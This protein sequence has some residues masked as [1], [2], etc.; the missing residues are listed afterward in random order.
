MDK[1]IL[2]KW[3]AAGYVERGQ[4]YPTEDGVPQGGLISATLLVVTLSGLERAIKAVVKKR[5][6]AKVNVCIYAD[7]FI[8]TGASREILEQRIMPVVVAFL[9]ERG[10]DL[11][12]DKTQISDIDQGFDFLSMSIR[13]YNNK[14]IIKPAKNGINRFKA[15]IRETIKNNATCKT[16]NLI[17]L[18]NPMIRGWANH[19]RH[20]CSKKIFVTIDTC[21]FEALWRWAKRRHPSKGKRWIYRKY[22]RYKDLRSGVFSTKTKKKGEPYHLDLVRMSATPIKRHI[23]IRSDA[24]PFDPAYHKYLDKRI[25]DRKNERKAERSGWWGRWWDQPQT[26]MNLNDGS[27]LAL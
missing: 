3:L 10:L 9:K 20:V 11:S 15:K 27:L 6:K 22:F 14:L 21:I 19:Y 23:K 12:I 24:T 17:H 18:L 16:E 25:S 1:K 7:D 5:D 26:N 2:K 8:I 4:L 13:K